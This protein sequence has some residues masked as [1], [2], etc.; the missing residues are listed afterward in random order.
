MPNDT[1]RLSQ[2][3]GVFGPGAM[4]DLPDRSVLVQG[5]DHWEMGGKRTFLNRRG[6]AAGP[7]AAPAPRRRRARGGRSPA[8]AAHAAA[9]P[10]GSPTPVAR[11]QGDRLPALVRL[12]RPGRRR[13]QPA[14]A[15]PVPHSH[16]PETARAPRRGRQAS[17]RFPHPLRVRLR[18]GTLCRT[19]SGARSST[20]LGRAPG[21]RPARR[22]ARSRC[23][24]S[25]GSAGIP[26][27]PKSPA[28]AE[29]R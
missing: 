21:A 7:P 13:A 19:S 20:R 6:A 18:R 29:R 11:H 2:L 12:R 3:V 23:G 8:R 24:L 22:G 14:A 27:T 28:I 15:R 25:T 17:A 26:A 4:L 5:L 10:R 1:V 9:R 16:T